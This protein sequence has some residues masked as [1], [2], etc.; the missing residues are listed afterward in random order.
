[1]SPPTQNPRKKRTPRENVAGGR[2]IPA[3]PLNPKYHIIAWLQ[4][5]PAAVSN[6]TF[7]YQQLL[8]LVETQLSSRDIPTLLPTGTASVFNFIE[9]RKVEAWSSPY[10]NPAVVAFILFVP[11]LNHAIA[12]FSAIA[13][14]CAFVN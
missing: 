6:L 5:S 14:V 13:S 7:T 1:M 12:M 10:G 3:T 8:K 2:N 9:V 4:L 11:A